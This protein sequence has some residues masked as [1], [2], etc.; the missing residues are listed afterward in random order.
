MTSATNREPVSWSKPHSILKSK[1]VPPSLAHACSTISNDRDGEVAKL[2]KELSGDRCVATLRQHLLADEVA[3]AG[4]AELQSRLRVGHETTQHVARE[5]ELQERIMV[6][7]VLLEDLED[8]I[9]KDG[10]VGDVGIP[11]QK[12]AGRNPSSDEL[13]RIISTLRAQR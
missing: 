11:V 7:V 9:G 10:A 8:E 5:V 2:L 12:A 3:G 13:E 6:H 4:A 1:Y